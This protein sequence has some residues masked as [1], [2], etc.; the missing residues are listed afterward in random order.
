MPALHRTLKNPKRLHRKVK[1]RPTTVSLAKRI[2]RI[3]NDEELKYINQNR[4]AVTATTS[5]TLQLLNGIAHG[6][7]AITREGDEVR[8]TSYNFRGSILSATDVLTPVIFRLIVFWDKQANGADPT[9]AGNPNTPVSALLDNQS[10]TNLV[11]SPIQWQNAERFRILYDRNF[12]L[13]PMVVGNTTAGATDGV[14]ATSK[15]IRIKLKLNRVTK[16]TGANSNIAAI[17]TNSLYMLWISDDD[18]T[19][20][21]GGRLYFKE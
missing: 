18:V 6:D 13:N 2:R 16:Y 3:E 21:G 15:L 19:F 9:I 20:E 4:T 8:W 7:T 11:Y 14:L 12:I 5:G 1:S 17:N 10:I